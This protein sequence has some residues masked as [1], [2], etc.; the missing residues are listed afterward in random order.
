MGTHKLSAAKPAGRGL[1]TR[2][3]ESSTEQLK[4][5][6]GANGNKNWMLL[7]MCW[8]CTIQG[9]IVNGLVPSTISTI[10]RRF[11]L[12]TSTIGRIMQVSVPLLLID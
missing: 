2:G 4:S 12:S 7:W 1:V 11:Q 3:A 8:F 5:G 10:E 6:G 9:I